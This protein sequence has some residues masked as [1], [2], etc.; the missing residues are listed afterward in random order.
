MSEEHA[1]QVDNLMLAWLWVHVGLLAGASHRV[2][3]VCSDNR[4]DTSSE[5]SCE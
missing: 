4:I 5:C 2:H 3:S 1:F